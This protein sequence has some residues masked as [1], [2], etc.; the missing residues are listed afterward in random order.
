MSESC[1]REVIHRGARFTFERVTTRTEGGAPVVRDVVRHPGAVVVLALDP[2]GRIIMIRNRR[3]A[4]GRTLLELPAGTLE[5]GEDPKECAR[6]ELAEETGY[7]PATLSAL[8]E[9]F[10]TPG[11]TDERM[12]P[13]IASNLTSVGQHLDDG[14]E[15]EVELV[16]IPEA[17]AKID[18]GQMEDAKSMLTILLARRR[19]FLPVRDDV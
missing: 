19:G 3:V 5:A 1:E 18:D 2:G 10:T 6:R 15:I 17:L 11:L 13:F 16:E 14:E 9:F 4:V 12:H 7:E 8:G